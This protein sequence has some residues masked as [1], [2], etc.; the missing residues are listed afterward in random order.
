MVTSFLGVFWRLAALDR[1]K[2][3]LYFTALCAM[4]WTKYNRVVTQKVKTA[5][6]TIGYRI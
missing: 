4:Y 2:S 5:I 3:A 6:A 1:K